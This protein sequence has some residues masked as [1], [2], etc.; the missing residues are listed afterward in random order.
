MNAGWHQPEWVC[1]SGLDRSHA[2]AII[3]QIL[4]VGLKPIARYERV[5]L[6]F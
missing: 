1:V 2:N 3:G 6:M 4:S 5:R